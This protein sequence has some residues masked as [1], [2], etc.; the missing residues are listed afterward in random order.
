MIELL[1]R[2]FTKDALEWMPVDV[3]VGGIEHGM[4]V[5]HITIAV[6]YDQSWLL[7]GAKAI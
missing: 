2:P 1:C 4:Y 6:S 3:Y 5:I 7:V